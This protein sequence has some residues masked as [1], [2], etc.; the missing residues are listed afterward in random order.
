[1][2]ENQLRKD[3]VLDDYVIIAERRGKRPHQFKK[4]PEQVSSAEHCPFCPGNE[5]MLPPI[6]E[7]LPAKKDTKSGLPWLARVVPNKFAAVDT[8]V[9]ARLKRSDPF[10]VHAGAYG[11]H[12]VV[13][14]TPEHG[15]ELEDLDLEHLQAVLE[16]YARRMRLIESMP[17][18]RYT[19]LFKNRGGEAG[20]SI[21]HAHAQLIGLNVFPPSVARLFGA[22][23][24]YWIKNESCVFCDVIAKE[25]H[26]HRLVF[27]NQSFVCIA[28]YASKFAFE[29][30]I[31]PL[32][33]VPAM[34][35]LTKKEMGDLAHILRKVLRRIDT[36]GNP[37]YNIVF[38]NDE[39]QGLFHF[40]LR[41]LPRLTKWAG[42]EHEVSIPINPVPPE[43]AAK[44]LRG[45]E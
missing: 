1:M 10:A 13:I 40:H 37:P 5:H 6:V 22:S 27:I 14:E 31:L 34:D 8:A 43:V 7:E 44:F 12:E 21:S 19:A 35:R 9:D 30:W 18:V 41:I 3:Y 32:R 42:F 29:T 20:A 45:H 16:L 15:V 17:H 33:H 2:K 24:Q 4:E 25:K 26:S 11:K 23:Y 39:E 36:L 38:F 28:P